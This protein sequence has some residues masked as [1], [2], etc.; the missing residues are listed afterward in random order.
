[1]IDHDY[2]SKQYAPGIGH[3][4]SSQACQD[5]IGVGYRPAAMLEASASVLIRPARG[6]HDAVERQILEHNN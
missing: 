3:A 6:L 5:P 4:F 2:F 1:L